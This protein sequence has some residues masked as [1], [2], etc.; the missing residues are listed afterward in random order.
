MKRDGFTLIEMVIVVAIL[1]LL[2]IITMMS[3][4]NQLNKARDAQRKDDLQRISIAFEEY[5]SDFGCYPPENILDNCGGG[6]LKPYLDKIPCDPVTDKPYEYVPDGDKPACPR[7]FRLLA[8]L[9]NE[10]DPAIASLGCAGELG[11]GWDGDPV[12]NYGV[13]SKNVAVGNPA[14]PSP[15]AAPSA[16]PGASPSPSPSPSGN[17]ACDPT[18]Q[19]NVYADPETAGCPVSF[20]DPV[21]CQQACDASPTNWCQQ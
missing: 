4:K 7:N 1:A 15:S 8:R 20:S 5:F 18:G 21:V 13:S 17:L 10:T 16:A 19:C 12:Y 11:C 9:G 3:W 6:E 14:L 2:L